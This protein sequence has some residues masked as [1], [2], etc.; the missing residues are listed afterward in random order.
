MVGKIMPA[1][2]LVG[3][4]S[5]VTSA[6]MSIFLYVGTAFPTRTY[7]RFLDPSADLFAEYSSLL[8]AGGRS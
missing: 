5:M 6:I 8:N 3:I 4:F 7:Q 2:A 1:L